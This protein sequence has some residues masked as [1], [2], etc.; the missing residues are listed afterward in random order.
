MN[1]IV[2]IQRERRRRLEPF[3]VCCVSLVYLRG[4]EVETQMD[5]VSPKRVTDISCICLHFISIP[6]CLLPPPLPPP[7]TSVMLPVMEMKGKSLKLIHLE[8][9]HQQRC[10]LET[11][12]PGV[13]DGQT[14]RAPEVHVSN[15]SSASLPPRLSW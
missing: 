8:V 10:S 1:I 7:R 13:G 6:I 12:R 4:S 2:T 15:K 5:A 9:S 3:L 11:Q 14:R